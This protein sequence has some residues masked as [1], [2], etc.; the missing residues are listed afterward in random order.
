[1]LHIFLKALASSY[2]DVSQVTSACFT[3]IV[4][5]VP[6]NPALPVKPV[7]A[8]VLPNS[9][10]ESTWKLQVNIALFS[11]AEMATANPCVVIN[12]CGFSKFLSKANFLHDQPSILI[13]DTVITA[14]RT[15]EQ[16]MSVSPALHY[17]AVAKL[18]AY[19]ECH[20]P[21]AG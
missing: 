19:F 18:P 1:M 10:I 3:W 21:P 11:G 6:A 8:F 7:C 5:F 9:L 12:T 2:S 15:F 17:R 16:L 20:Q 14:V 13:V 4:Q